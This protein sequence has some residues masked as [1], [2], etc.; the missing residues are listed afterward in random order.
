MRSLTLA[1]AV[2]SAFAL[3]IPAQA[4][5][6]TG[7]LPLVG[8]YANGPMGGNDK[9]S[10]VIEVIDAFNA[11]NNPDL[12][13][14]IMLFKKTD[15]DAAFMFSA[16]PPTNGFEFFSDALGT[17]QITAQAGLTALNDAYFRYTG[18]EALE[19]YSVKSS[20]GFSLY[21][22][23]AGLNLLTR[24]D[25]NQG[26]SHA[27][28]W[29]STSPPVTTTVNIPEPSTFVIWSMLLALG[30]R[31]ASRRRARAN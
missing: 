20:T 7:T 18:P 10:S 24:D 1:T 4:A 16:T 25:T 14:D 22:F 11:I 5:I 29:K 9:I 3:S 2:L 15:D 23:G 19:Y 17:S 12:T 28:F 26:I 21:Q 6:I 30:G 27:S 8:T 13:T 31:R